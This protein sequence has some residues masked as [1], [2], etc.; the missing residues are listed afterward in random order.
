MAAE[1]A[2]VYGLEAAP[3]P[4]GY[5]PLEAAVVLKCLDEDGDTVLL[6]RTTSTLALWDRIG[7]LTCALDTDRETMRNGFEPDLSDEDEEDED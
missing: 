1:A 4:E 2:Q 3:L 7:M 6:T 5:V